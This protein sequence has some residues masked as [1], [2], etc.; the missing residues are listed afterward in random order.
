MSVKPI[1]DSLP[2][3]CKGEETILL[4][5]IAQNTQS[6]AQAAGAAAPAEPSAF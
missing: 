6:T 5:Q 2:L 3:S 1:T 4:K